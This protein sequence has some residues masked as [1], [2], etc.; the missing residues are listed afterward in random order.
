L[1]MTEVPVAWANDD[2]SKVNLIVDGMKMFY[3]LLKIRFYGMTG[4]YDRPTF[5]F[6]ASTPGTVLAQ[7]KRPV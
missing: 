6:F 1:K 2:R 3:E 7:G 4:Q 5:Q